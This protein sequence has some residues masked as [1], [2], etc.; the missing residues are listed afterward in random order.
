MYRFVPGC[1]PNT[2]LTYYLFFADLFLRALRL[3]NVGRPS[4]DWLQKI[5]ITCFVASYLVVLAL[6][7]SRMFFQTNLRSI[8]RLGLMAAGLFAHTVFIAFH[9]QSSVGS[10][11]IWL[12]SWLGWGLAVAWM[13]AASYLWL[14]IAKP[15]S[16]IGLFLLPVTLLLILVSNAWGD[17][18][19]FTPGRAKTVW[20]LIHGGALLMGTVT[21]A[22]GFVFSVMY[23][24]N[25]RR[26]KQKLTGWFK[27]PSLEWLQTSAERSLAVSTALFACGLASGIALVTVKQ[28]TQAAPGPIPWGDPVIW[29]SAILFSWLLLAT[30]FIVFYRPARQGK[31]IAWLVTVSFLFL[32]VELLIILQFGHATPESNRAGSESV[33]YGCYAIPICDVFLPH[34]NAVSTPSTSRDGS[35]IFGG[36]A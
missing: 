20:N 23:L 7:V 31:K 21:V 29:S 2:R 9:T 24:V 34:Q 3:H 30:L 8:L 22:L 17:S 4:L 11:G 35:Y 18:R 36:D 5:S 25:A 33:R 6:E 12:G 32:I 15:K 1:L 28:S 27:L 13:L 14:T 10:D 19:P 16:L 26:L